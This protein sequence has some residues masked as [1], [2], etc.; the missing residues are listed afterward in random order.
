MADWAWVP[1]PHVGAPRLSHFSRRVQSIEGLPHEED[2]SSFTGNWLALIELESSSPPGLTTRTRRKVARRAM[3]VLISV[4]GR[5]RP[6]L[7]AD[8]I[9]R[10]TC[11]PLLDVQLMLETP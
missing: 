10:L 5:A 3:G 9:A 7:L 8:E 4:I 6:H 2:P 11:R 1:W